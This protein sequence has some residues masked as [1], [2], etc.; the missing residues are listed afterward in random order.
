M[1]QFHILQCANLINS[2]ISVGFFPGFFPV[3]SLRASPR[4]R[5]ARAR[6]AQERRARSTRGALKK[7]FRRARFFLW[8]FARADPRKRARGRR[9]A[10]RAVVAL[11]HARSRARR[12][13][14]S[15]ERGGSRV[16]VEATVIPLSSEVA[17]NPLPSPQR[18]EGPGV[19][20]PRVPASARAPS[21][22]PSPQRG[23]G[24][25]NRARALCRYQWRPRAGALNVERGTRGD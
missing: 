10:P 6:R 5:T 2:A 8:F 18:G 20:G 16:L 25:R 19:R 17:R 13:A 24:A 21:P 23:E 4:A 9:R 1:V 15:C 7:K 12:R 3:N 14:A 11:A 22:Q